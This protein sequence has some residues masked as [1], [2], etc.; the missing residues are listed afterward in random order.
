MSARLTSWRS[1][2]ASLMQTSAAADGWWFSP[3]PCPRGTRSCNRLVF[4]Q[5]PVLARDVPGLMGH[6]GQGWRTACPVAPAV[7]MESAGKRKNTTATM[8]TD[9]EQTE[10]TELVGILT[11][12]R[13]DH[14]V[15]RERTL[16]D[17]PVLHSVAESRRLPS[18]ETPLQGI[19]VSTMIGHR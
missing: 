15:L 11:V 10:A 4:G 12:D 9:R 5:Q 14:P 6:Q 7:A 8:Q 2:Q 1:H 19:A 18:Q 3:V 16:Q 17:A 13:R